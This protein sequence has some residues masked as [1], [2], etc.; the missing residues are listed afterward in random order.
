[1]TSSSYIGT[2]GWTTYA[3][4]LIQKQST[5][6]TFI[7]P[8]GKQKSNEVLPENIYNMDE[9]DFMIGVTERSKKIFNRVTW[10]KKKKTESI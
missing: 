7:Y 6:C 5:S 3:T 2:L 4:K 8:V 10:E 1:M 9:K